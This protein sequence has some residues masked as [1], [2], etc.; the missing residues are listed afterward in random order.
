MLNGEVVRR[1][2]CGEAV[3]RTYPEGDGSGTG[4]VGDGWRGVVFE[5]TVFE[6]TVLAKRVGEPGGGNKVSASSLSRSGREAA[7]AAGAV[8]SCCGNRS[9]G[10]GT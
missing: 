10:S 5:W 9:R 1:D 2:P 4:Q 7:G 8:S 3:S 6:W